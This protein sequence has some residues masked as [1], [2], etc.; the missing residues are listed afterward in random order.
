MLLVINFTKGHLNNNNN[1]CFFK[2]NNTFKFFFEI[3]IHY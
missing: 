3:L 1:I 2:V